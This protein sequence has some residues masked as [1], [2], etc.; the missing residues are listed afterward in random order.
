MKTDCFFATKNK[1]YPWEGNVTKSKCLLT[2]FLTCEE[3]TKKGCSLLDR[4]KS[5]DDLRDQMKKWGRKI[6]RKKEKVQIKT[7]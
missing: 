2:G 4:I 5:D 6:K 7:K 3:E 1:H